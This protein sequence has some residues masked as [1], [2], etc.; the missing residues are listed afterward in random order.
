MTS[1]I[2]HLKKSSYAPLSVPTQRQLAKHME[3]LGTFQEAHRKVLADV[4]RFLTTVNRLSA[5]PCT[6]AETGIA[7]L[8][9]LRREAYE[10]LNQI[11]HEH[12]IVRAAEWLLAEQ[13]CAP[14]TL[15]FWN[16]RQTGDG[17]EPDL[18]G[19]HAS[20]IVV[21]AEITT[22]EKPVGTNDSRMQK[23]LAKLAEMQGDKFYFVRTPQMQQR[24]NTKIAKG[25]WKIEVVQLAV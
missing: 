3:Q 20:V 7:I 22:S 21:S 23:T 17:S 2:T 12:L 25:G 13:R 24:A 1:K 11:Q 4:Q 10:D 8:D 14:E 19:S 5:M 6:N 18:R 9:R 15:W 16:P